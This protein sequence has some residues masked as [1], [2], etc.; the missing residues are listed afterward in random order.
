MALVRAAASRQDAAY[1]LHGAGRVTAD[2]QPAVFVSLLP[3]VP[4]AC[5]SRGEALP[6]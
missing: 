4:R 2:R 6:E 5:R 3:D 1:R